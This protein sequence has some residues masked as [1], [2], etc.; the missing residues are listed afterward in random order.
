MLQRERELAEFLTQRECSRRIVRRRLAA[1]GGALEQEFYR[2]RLGEDI[3]LQGLDF[4]AEAGEP[5]RHHDMP[6]G[7]PAQQLIGLCERGPAVDIVEDQAQPGL[8]LSQPIAASYCASCSAALASAS[9]STRVSAAMLAR[10]ESGVSPV[11]NS[12]AL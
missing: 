7:E 8:R 6:A 1:L 4:A 10:S 12:S 11:A 3:E 2:R 5:A 9:R